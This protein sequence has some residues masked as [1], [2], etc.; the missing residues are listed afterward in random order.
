MITASVVLFHTSQELIDT[1]TES[2]SPSENRRLFLVDNSP[3]CP[4]DTDFT[5]VSPDVFIYHTGANLG[6]GSAH[7]IV[8]KKAI[9]LGSEFHVVLNPDLS[10]DPSVIDELADYARKHPEV[11][12]MLPEVVNEHGQVQHLCKLLPTPAD[13]I[14]RRFFSFLPSA[15]EKNDR[16]IL[17]ATGY[18]HIMNVPCLSGCF[19]FMRT[20]TLAKYD[21][22]F[23]ERFFMYCEDFDLMRR[24][25]RVGQTI[26]Y[27]YAQI[28]HHHERSSYHSMKM[29]MHHIASAVKYFNK[30]GWWHDQEREHVNSETLLHLKTS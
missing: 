11:V 12:Y 26:Y 25:H 4:R 7:N 21:L 18:D 24:L 30:Y 19:M 8:I 1:V 15:S 2:F 9:A 28:T 27:P 16:Y 10:F 6:Y 29:L 5:E 13:L 20:E 14:F 22:I 23:D 17:L 3:E